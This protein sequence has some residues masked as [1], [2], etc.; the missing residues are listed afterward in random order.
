[1]GAERKQMLPWRRTVNTYTCFNAIATGV[2]GKASIHT[3]ASLRD[4]HKHSH[5]DEIENK[6]CD[7]LALPQ[8]SAAVPSENPFYFE[9]SSSFFL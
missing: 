6:I 1:M 2:R 9:K 3:S 7:A 8:P 4:R 5:S